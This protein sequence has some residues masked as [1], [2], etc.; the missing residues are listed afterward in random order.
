MTNDQIADAFALCKKYG[1]HSSAFLMIGMPGETMAQMNETIDLMVRIGP[2]RMRWSVFYPFPGTL[3]YKLAEE[4]GKIDF[5]RLKKLDNYFVTT[6]LKFDSETELFVNK[7]QRVFHWYVNA[8]SGGPA[9]EV[10]QAELKKIEAMDLATWASNRDRVLEIDRQISDNLLK[11]GVDHYSIRYTEVM[12][13][14]SEYLLKE[15]PKYRNQKTRAWKAS[16]KE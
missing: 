7:L 15:D 1:L 12:A 8:R 9:A 4:W 6:A 11:Q 10:Y 14:H 5:D 3:S 16:V 13:V 2:G